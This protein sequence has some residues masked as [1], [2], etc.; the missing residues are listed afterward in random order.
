VS[1]PYADAIAA[2]KARGRQNDPA[3]EVER[4]D[5][6]QEDKP[7]PPAL[8]PETLEGL[9]DLAGQA[10]KAREGKEDRA[11]EPTKDPFEGP[12]PFNY[13]ELLQKMQRDQMARKRKHIESLLDQMDVGDLLSKQRI[14]QDVPIADGV[15][16]S[17]RSSIGKEELYI[18]NKISLEDER[19]SDM[20]LQSKLGLLVLTAGLTAIGSQMLPDHIDENGNIN[21]DIFE[22]KFERIISQ[23]TILLTEMSLNHT[24]FQERVQA[25]LTFG[26]LKNG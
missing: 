4:K 9:K 19:S 6:F 1:D 8:R 12:E 24:W 11:P 14:E 23:P 20:Y 21:P 2:A 13:Y 5:S 7:K 16:V 25:L 17:F 26:A 22:K 10:Q 3:P 18:K 15:T